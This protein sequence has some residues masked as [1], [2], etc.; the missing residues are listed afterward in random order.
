MTSINRNW[1]K[2]VR[3]WEKAVDKAEKGLIDHNYW[4]DVLNYTG[5]CGFCQEFVHCSDCLLGERGQGR[6]CSSNGLILKIEKLIKRGDK[7]GI[8][9]YCRAILDVVLRNEF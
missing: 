8:E 4:Q 1:L 9:I 6:I 2:S 3:K 5:N 7:Q